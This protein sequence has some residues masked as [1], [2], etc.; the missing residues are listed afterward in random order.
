MRKDN[1]FIRSMIS[2]WYAYIYTYRSIKDIDKDIDRHEPA[3]MRVIQFAQ[4]LDG[5]IDIDR[6]ID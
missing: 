6:L 1:K 4:V 3:K 2:V 5:Y